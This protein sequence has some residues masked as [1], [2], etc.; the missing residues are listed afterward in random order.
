MDAAVPG[1]ISVT[2]EAGEGHYDVGQPIALSADVAVNATPYAGAT[3]NATITK[4]DNT[5]A[6]VALTDVGGG[7][8]TGSFGDTAACGL[9]QVTATAVGSDGGTPFSRQDRTIAFVGV[10]GNVIMDPCTADSDGDGITD[11]DEINIHHTNPG[12]ADTDGDGYTDKQEID[13]GKDPSTYCNIMRAD[14]DHDGAV[15]ILDLAKLAQ[16]FTQAIPPAPTAYDQDGDNKISILDL[17]RMAQVFT[18][19]VSTCP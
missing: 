11:S 6:T 2:A 4:P 19:P 3:V 13:M 1:D 15:S 17:A 10:P 5:T 12:N 7:T 16:Y 18:Q 9:Y 8:Y 14:V